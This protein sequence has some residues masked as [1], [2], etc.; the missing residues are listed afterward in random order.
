[1][2]WFH[3]HAVIRTRA[4]ARSPPVFEVRWLQSDGPLPVTG[5]PTRAPLAWCTYLAYPL[6]TIVP[7]TTPDRVNPSCA[8]EMV[9]VI[10]LGADP[11]VA[12]LVN[13][14]PSEVKVRSSIAG[15]KMPV[16]PDE[17]VRWATFQVVAACALPLLTT[18]VPVSPLG[19]SKVP[20]KALGACDGAAAAPITGSCKSRNDGADDLLAEPL[21]RQQHPVVVPAGQEVERVD[22]RRQDPQVP[23][24]VQ[25]ADKPGSPREDEMR[26]GPG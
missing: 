7:D 4:V 1:M 16:P 3:G 6:C 15:T 23:I 17:N 19:Q 25:A 13:V 11:F 9:Q 10:A 18:K 20:D 26:C 14:C 8:A 12:W 24:G 5:S 21:S 2:C 22:R